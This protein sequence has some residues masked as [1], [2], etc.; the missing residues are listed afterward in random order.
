[1]HPRKRLTF[2]RHKTNAPSQTA[3]IPDT[4]M[5]ILPSPT[6]T[7]PDAA[8][9]TLPGLKFARTALRP[10]ALAALP[11]ASSAADFAALPGLTPEQRS[12]GAALDQACPGAAGTL[13]ARCTQLEALSPQQ[14]QQAI[15]QLTPYQ[16]LPQSGM[17]IKLRMAQIDTRARQAA[18]RD[19]TAAMV[20]GEG[21]H[22]ENGN[23]SGDMEWRDGPL[24]LFAQGKFQS[25]G[26]DKGRSSFNFDTYNLT[27]GA[28]YR[29]TDD[30]VLGLATGYTRTDAM[31]TQDSGH[32][33]TNALLGAFYGSYLLPWEAYIDW[34]ATYGSFNNDLDRNFAYPGFAG[35]ASSSPD[36]AQYGFSAS[37]G[38]DFGLDAWTLNPYARVEYINLQLDP[39]QERGGDGLNYQVGQQSYDSFISVAGLSVGH[40]FSLSWG[41]LTPSIRFEWEH[42][43]L[44]DNQ[45][46]NIHLADAAPGTGNFFLTTGNPDRDYANLGGAITAAF[47][48]GGGAFLRY[49]AR[50]GQSY[51]NSNLVE[52]G[53]R[54]PF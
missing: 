28:D 24:A 32:M 14:Q 1:M 12:L 31:L 20:D 22:L 51:L 10:L 30:L 44:N 38:K 43:Y 27:I 9:P 13:G 29:V 46:L 11:L 35:R 52:I 5:H 48:G 17:P 7:D 16:F 50:L 4:T 8:T 33:G 53:L 18:L 39:Y 47:A 23:G 37:V 2:Q 36:A 21:N 15:V 49:E 41:V 42:Q 25:G 40:A 54:L 45:R 34:A 3:N 19:D 26:K 6:G